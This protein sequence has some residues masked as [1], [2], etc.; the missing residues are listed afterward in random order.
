MTRGKGRERKRKKKRRKKRERIPRCGLF[1]RSAR[2]KAARSGNGKRARHVHRLRGCGTRSISRSTYFQPLVFLS[3]PHPLD[4]PSLIPVLSTNFSSPLRV[5]SRP[6]SFSVPFYPSPPP[7][8]NIR[9]P[10]FSFFP[11]Q[12][13]S[14]KSIRS[15]RFL[16]S[17]CNACISQT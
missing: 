1:H 15:D 3:V 16:F 9:V 12:T 7:P 6:Y 10:F 4:S 2:R 8:F 14:L 5:Q 11:G 17:N 13:R